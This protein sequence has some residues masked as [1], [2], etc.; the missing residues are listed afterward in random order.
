M[1][2]L[3]ACAGSAVLL[4]AVVLFMARH[5]PRP[6]VANEAQSATTATIRCTAAEPVLRRAEPD[7]EAPPVILWAAGEVRLFLDVKPEFSP[8]ESPK[9][10]AP[11]VHV[12]RVEAAG[13]E[14]FETKLRLVSFQPALI[15]AQADHQ[16]GVTLLRLGAIC[17]SCDAPVAPLTEFTG[18]KSRTPTHALFT[19]AAA[20]LRKDQWAHASVL[21]GSVAAKE[22]SSATYHRLASAT[23]LACVAASVVAPGVTAPPTPRRPPRPVG[24]A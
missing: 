14:P 19:Q 8:P 17:A 9:H 21:L 18:E 4:V 6:P 15:H 20:W 7:A 12:L 10:F 2:W 1:L 5:A 3:S 13:A 16:V 23:W 22:R 11:G 24:R